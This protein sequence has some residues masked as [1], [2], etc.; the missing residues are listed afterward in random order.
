MVPPDYKIS[1]VKINTCVSVS[2]NKKVLAHKL[3]NIIIWTCL[4]HSS[5]WR[6]WESNYFLVMQIT[7]IQNK[8]VSVSGAASMF[9]VDS[10]SFTFSNCF[11]FCLIEINHFH[12]QHL[13]LE[14]SKICAVELEKNTSLLKDFYL[15]SPSFPFSF[16]LVLLYLWPQGLSL[17]AWCTIVMLR[18]NLYSPVWD[19]FSGMG[20]ILLTGILCFV[21]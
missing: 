13:H 5:V 20:Q 9:R 15:L 1:L 6:D 8:I 10:F 12:L 18:E 2:R 21:S 19:S 3:L 7:W 11:Y 4:P 16:V 17:G 14:F